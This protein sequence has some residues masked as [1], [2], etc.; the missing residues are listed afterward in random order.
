MARTRK[1]VMVRGPRRT[2]PETFKQRERR[3]IRLGYRALVIGIRRAHLDA[4]WM[5]HFK[6]RAEALFNLASKGWLHA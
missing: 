5:L 6:A 1:V 3:L 2:A 4:G